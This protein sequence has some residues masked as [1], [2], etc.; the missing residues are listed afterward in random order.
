MIRIAPRPFSFAHWDHRTL[1]L[2]DFLKR[3]KTEDAAAVGYGIDDLSRRL[4]LLPRDLES[5]DVR[6]GEF[7]VP[8]RSGGHRTI[9]APN[10]Q[11]KSVQKQINRRL[12]A[13]LVAHP[14][15]TGFERG[16]SI[17]HHARQHVGK[18][19]VIRMDIVDFFPSIAEKRIEKFFRRIGW[20]RSASKLLTRLCTHQGQ[21]PQGAP[22]SPRLSNLVNHRLDARLAGLARLVGAVYSRY[23]D[24]LTF[25]FEIEL[26]EAIPTVIRLTKKIVAD[27]GYRLHTKKKLHIRRQHQQQRVTGLVVN[28]KI[29]LPRETRR[30]LRAIRHRLASGQQ[31]TLT[32]AQL[33]GW[34]ALESMIHRQRDET[35]ESDPTTA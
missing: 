2:F 26:R 18:A 10:E 8:K 30:R 16:R 19:V 15:A 29:A 4:G 14:C 32:E 23:A 6:Y 17:V 12:L 21:L 20:D 9:H 31:A 3:R 13:L 27:E 25:S 22:T 35:P 24:D 1:G 28:E 11:L 5:I 33:A 7:K 34:S